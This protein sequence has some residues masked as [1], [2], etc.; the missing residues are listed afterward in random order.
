MSYS[1]ELFPPNPTFPWLEEHVELWTTA[2]ASR[3]VE[4][5]ASIV[6]LARETVISR[7]GSAKHYAASINKIPLALLV[8]NDIHAEHIRLDQTLE[9]SNNDTRPGV[10]IFDHSENPDVPSTQPRTNASVQ[11]LLHDL[12]APSGNTAARA[13]VN[14]SLGSAMMVNDRFAHELFL[15]HTRL[16]VLSD[17]AFYLGKTTSDEALANVVKLV[18][19]GSQA[20]QKAR[21]ALIHNSYPDYGVRHQLSLKPN[22]G[23]AVAAK[24]GI[25]DND[26]DNWGHLR[27]DAGVIYIGDR[28][29][30]GY[31]FLNTEPVEPG[32]PTSSGEEA[33]HKA[34]DSLTILGAGL[35]HLASASVST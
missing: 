28:P 20:G 27:H 2:A 3:G 12:L 11:E 9:W 34:T 35:I 19:D 29:A 15:D 25:L 8:A 18:N 14:H 6:D 16:E 23:L 7:A 32:K 26:A 10:G 33:G 5:S 1:Y 31:A 4:A 17:Q 22:E 13:L 21:A 24:P 30:Y